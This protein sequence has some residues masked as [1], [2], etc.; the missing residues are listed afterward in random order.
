MI[1]NAGAGLALA[2]RRPFHVTVRR[3]TTAATAAM[4][5]SRKGSAAQG[6]GREA[7]PAA[8]RGRQRRL[9]T[10]RRPSPTAANCPSAVRKKASGD[11]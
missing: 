4:A 3:R 1:F 6:S 7:N 5:F 2:D 8:V 11:G 9:M 10:G